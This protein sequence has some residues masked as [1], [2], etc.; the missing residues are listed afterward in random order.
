M[1]AG[2]YSVRVEMAGFRTEEMDGLRI[3]VG[4]QASITIPLQVTGV[5]TSIT[6]AVPTPEELSAA[7]NAIGSVVDSLRFASFR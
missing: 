1:L 5:Q 2:D 7:S 6:V 4:Q 3:E